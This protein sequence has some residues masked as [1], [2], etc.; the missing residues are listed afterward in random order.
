MRRRDFLPLAL[1]AVAW[2]CAETAA[3]AAVKRIGFLY[4]GL[5]AA[6]S[7]RIAA[8]EEGLG[9]AGIRKEQIELVVRNAEGDPGKIPGFAKELLAQHLDLLIAV[10]PVAIAAFRSA[11]SIPI[12]ANDLESDPVAS[13]LVQSLAHPGGNI[14]GVFFDFPDFSSKW[15]E[16]LK[17]TLPKLSS[18]VVIWHPAMGEVQ[19]TSIQKAAGTLNVHIEVLKVQTIDGLDQTFADASR[20]RPDAVLMLSS[21][22]IGTN[23]QRAAD[24]A[25]RYKLPAITLFPEFAQAG[26]LM[27]YGADLLAVFRQMG[28]MASKVLN[29]AKTAD[30]PI[31]RPSTYELVI[32]LKTAKALGIAFPP[33]V[34]GRADRVVE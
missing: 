15:L 26:G 8:F 24:L 14:T 28:L 3:A 16:L 29:G 12:I 22:L 2:P 5:S 11:H 23:P 30:L 19:L 7:S 27:A 34:L 1:M 13:G 18:V 20:L 17:E 10:S 21:P 33:P 9:A 32:N 31:E 4:P 25:M 6:S